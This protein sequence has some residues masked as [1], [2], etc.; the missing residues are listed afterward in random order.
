MRSY[1]EIYVIR[2]FYKSYIY[3]PFNYYNYGNSIP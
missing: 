3:N 2:A 1:R